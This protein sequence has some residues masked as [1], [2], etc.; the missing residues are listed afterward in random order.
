MFDMQAGKTDAN[1]WEQGAVWGSMI[2]NTCCLF[3]TCM[4]PQQE[5]EHKA[6]LQ[7][8]LVTSGLQLL[9]KPFLRVS[10]ISDS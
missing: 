4:V 3:P 10:S 7:L 2:E 9:T 1:K 8:F 6:P 5:Q